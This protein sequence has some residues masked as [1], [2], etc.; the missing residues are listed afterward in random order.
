VTLLVAAPVF[1][2]VLE[3][4]NGITNTHRLAQDVLQITVMGKLLRCVFTVILWASFAKNLEIQNN[5]LYAD[6]VIQDE[7]RR[8]PATLPEIRLSKMWVKISAVIVLV[9]FVVAVVEHAAYE[10]FEERKGSRILHRSL[11]HYWY[12]PADTSGWKKKL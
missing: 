11:R 1:S 2:V 7:R 3:L 9:I 4:C 8:A 10:E 12:P 5:S 6:N